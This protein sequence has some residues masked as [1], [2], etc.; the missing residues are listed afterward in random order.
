MVYITPIYGYVKHFLANILAIFVDKLP[1]LS[2]TIVRQRI[3]SESWL[4]KII[5]H[6]NCRQKP[7]EMNPGTITT[8]FA[9]PIRPLASS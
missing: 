1:H 9:F 2:S 3:A 8:T 7:K 4:P 5:R 6:T